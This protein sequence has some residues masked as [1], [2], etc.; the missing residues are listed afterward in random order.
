MRT[1]ICVLAL[2]LVVGLRPAIEER[3]GGAPVI[4][5][6]V[7]VLVATVAMAA[8]LDMR[9]RNM[10]SGPAYV[11]AQ[12]ALVRHLAAHVGTYDGLY[13]GGAAGE[14]AAWCAFLVLP[15][16]IV[17]APAGELLRRSRS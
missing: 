5:L 7:I 6:S 15:L 17:A 9:D 11:L 2:D 10:V 1:L 8:R 13:A 14:I 3:I 4:A 16:A 12:L